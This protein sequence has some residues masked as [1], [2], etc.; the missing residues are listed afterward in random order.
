MAPYS[1]LFDDEIL[2][3][4]ILFSLCSL[5]S[6]FIF[7][8][9]GGVGNVTP[10]SSEFKLSFLI[11]L[12]SFCP[13]VEAHTFQCLNQGTRKLTPFFNI[14]Q[15]ALKG[16]WFLDW[17]EKKKGEDKQTQVGM[18]RVGLRIEKRYIKKADT[19]FVLSAK[20]KQNVLN[21]A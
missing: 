4:L 5:G 14:I 11:T 19:T 7:W 6:S 8:G 3:S 18:T 21:V 17:L 10:F 20:V 2:P 12:A 13:L 9:G 1:F 15:G 16:E